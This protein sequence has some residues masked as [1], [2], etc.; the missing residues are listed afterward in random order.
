MPNF[1]K[2]KTMTMHRFLSLLAEIGHR[3]HP[4]DE[5]RR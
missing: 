1:D 4:P 5:G 3:L 2:R